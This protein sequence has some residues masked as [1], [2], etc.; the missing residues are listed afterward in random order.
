[1][2]IWTDEQTPHA[3]AEEGTSTHWGDVPEMDWTHRMVFDATRV[4][5][6]S[7]TYNQYGA[8]DDVNDLLAYGMAS[9]WST[10]GVIRSKHKWTKKNIF[11]ELEYWSTR[12][13]RYNLNVIHIKKNVFDNIFSTIMDIKEKMKD[14]LNT[15][16]DL[17]II[18]NRSE[19]KVDE[20]RPNVMPKAVYTLTKEQKR[21]ICE[22]ISHLKFLD[23][24]TSNLARC[25]DMKEREVSLLFQILCL[26]TLDVKKVQELEATVVC[27]W[28]AYTIQVDVSIQNKPCRNDDPSMNKTRIEQSIFNYPGRASGASKKTCPSEPE[29]HIIDT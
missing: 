18:C 11:C 4:A 3:L 26:T 1:M 10:A 7:Y 14:N 23:G 5:F 20:G 8:P 19:L 15:W 16:K 24:Y 12:L 13:I 9:G 25:V 29:R 28:E 27:A 2:Y 21:R 22:W 17:K 6:C